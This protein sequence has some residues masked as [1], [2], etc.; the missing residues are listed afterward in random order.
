MSVILPL[1]IVLAGTAFFRFTQA[2]LVIAEQFHGGLVG[3]P[4]RKAEPWLSL[5]RWGCYPGLVMGLGGLAVAAASRFWPRLQVW[6]AEGLFLGLLLLLGPGL[7]VNL[8]LK[9]FCSRPRPSQVER[10]GG[11]HPFLPIGQLGSSQPCRSFPSGHAS[12]G[13]Y[14]M[15][16][17]FVLYRRRPRWAAAFVGLGLA[18]GLLIGV[19]RIV[20]GQHFASDVLWSFGVVYF[21]ALPLAYLYHRRAE[22]RTAGLECPH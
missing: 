21:T 3:W 14:L 8:V 18:G 7:M 5:Y 12:M 13:F 15:A 22:P 10:F 6:R 11:Q 2:D 1:A 19:G 20:Q 16:P 17:A 9:E 4:G